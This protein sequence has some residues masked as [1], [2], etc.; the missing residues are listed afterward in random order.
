M[1]AH[2]INPLLDSIIC[3]EQSFP[4]T[5]ISH[6][7][8]PLD[9]IMKLKIKCWKC[10]YCRNN[11]TKCLQ[12]LLLYCILQ[13]AEGVCLPLLIICSHSH[14]THT[15]LTICIL[16]I[17]KEKEINL[18]SLAGKNVKMISEHRSHILHKN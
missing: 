9:P 10:T 17:C 13:I 16:K 6:M 11:L 15:Y 8:S 3:K 18:S 12:N 2:L 4:D 14:E 1:G 5:K 7:I